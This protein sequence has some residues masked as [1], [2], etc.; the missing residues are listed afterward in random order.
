MM[1]NEVTIG[2]ISRPV[3]YGWS[4]LAMFQDMTGMSLT[5]LSQLDSS[6]MSM[7]HMIMFAYCGLKD[8]ARKAKQEFPYD[9]ED[10]A[11][12]MDE[13]ADVFMKMFGEFVRNLTPQD[14]KRQSGDKKKAKS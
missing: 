8:G 10:V 12:W 13:D 14:G 4:A 11:D 1:I 2:G 6:K 7:R 3:R 9:P 5:E